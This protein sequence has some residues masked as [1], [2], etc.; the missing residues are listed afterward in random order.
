MLINHQLEELQ[1]QTQQ[2]IRESLTRC[3][4]FLLKLVR[5]KF[6]DTNKDD[7]HLM[8]KVEDVRT[9]LAMAQSQSR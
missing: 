5:Q 7:S 4:P 8:L 9:V 2:P 1:D 6:A 3:A